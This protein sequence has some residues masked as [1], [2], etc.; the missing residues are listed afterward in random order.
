MERATDLQQNLLFGG[1]AHP[2]RFAC[3]TAACPLSI[4][5]WRRHIRTVWS[6]EQEAIW[7]HSREDY[8]EAR[9]VLGHI[10][11]LSFAAGE[12]NVSPQVLA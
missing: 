10:R 2:T 5:R 7:Q 12:R 8:T 3:P 9:S 1:L 11:E 4:S 6:S